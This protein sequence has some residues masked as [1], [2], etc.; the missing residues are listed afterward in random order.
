MLAAAERHD[1]LDPDGWAAI[2]IAAAAIEQRWQEPD[3]GIWE[4][5]P[6]EW[7]HSRL[8]CAAGLR[9][10]ARTHRAGAD[11]G[12]FAALADAI[13]AATAATSQHRTGRWQRNP[14]DDRV[15]AAL[16]LP[17]IRGALPAD[18]PAYEGNAGGGA[19]RPDRRRVRLPLPAW[20]PATRPRRGRL[21]LCGF[22]VSL[23]LLQRGDREA[24]ARWFERTRASCG[25][26]GLF[27][28]EYDVLQ[29]QLRGNL[30]QA[31]VHALLVETAHRLDRAG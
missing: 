8:A 7:T 16:L 14:A 12:R 5:G 4:I 1:R 23:A 9:A 18:D 27:T 2:L 30:P 21:L 25:P 6:A 10:V 13:V 22:L 3:S 15:D 28:E 11:A 20:R 26:P 29:R 17:G 19:G 24:A 31:F